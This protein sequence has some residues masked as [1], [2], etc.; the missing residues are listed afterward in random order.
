VGG[1]VTLAASPRD[2][3]GAALTGRSVTW[4]STSPAVATV[5]ASGMVTGV[6]PGSVTIDAISEGRSGT[7]TITV[8]PVPVASVQ[9]MPATVTLMPGT[10]QQFTAT[11]RDSAGG[12]LANRSVT[13]STASPAVA[14]V[15]AQ[16]LVTAMAAG[17]T[18][19]TAAVEGRSATAMVTVSPMAPYQWSGSWDLGWTLIGSP[20]PCPADLSTL[21]SRLPFDINQVTSIRRP[22][23][24]NP[25]SGYK[26]H[27]H[28]RFP[29]ADSTGQQLI[30]APADGWLFGAARY[31]EAYTPGNDQ[32]ILDFYTDC[33]V[34]WRFDH[35][36]DGRLSPAMA[37]AIAN[38]PRR[39]DSQGMRLTPVR[40][41]AGE[42]P[43][44][45]RA[46][47]IRPRA[48]S[49]RSSADRSIP[50]RGSGSAGSTC[51]PA[52]VMP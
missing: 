35:L 36:R 12:T 25:Q 37:A 18:A 40:V 43:A 39:E 3:A 33:G 1:T 7:A 48:P 32:V 22:G 34:M 15:S 21:F 30:H 28:V 11:P 44:N 14:T 52:R 13:W 24:M 27:A 4:I 26:A 31:V 29:A 19:F 5:S 17:S 38:V 20:P 45:P 6:A 49:R 23:Y 51:F 47:S 9:V 10:I 46:S 42:C 2:A 8:Q 41:R 16:G 50:S